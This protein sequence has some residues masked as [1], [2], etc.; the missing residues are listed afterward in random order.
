MQRNQGGLDCQGFGL[1]QGSQTG[2]SLSQGTYQ[3]LSQ[4]FSLSQGSCQTA[5]S[6]EAESSEDMDTAD[7]VSSNAQPWGIQPFAGIGKRPLVSPASSPVKQ[8]PKVRSSTQNTCIPTQH[9]SAMEC[10]SS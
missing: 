9:G 2:S 1:S 8:K 6:V 7:T 10:Q 4:A 5:V 3:G